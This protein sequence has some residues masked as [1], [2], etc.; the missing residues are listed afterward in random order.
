MQKLSS[1]RIIFFVIVG[2][3]LVVVCL[4][5]AANFIIKPLQATPTPAAVM[6]TG[7][8]PA[9]PA[10]ELKSPAPVF[11]PGVDTKDGLP[12][13]VCG[14]DS[15]GSYFILQQMQMS[16]KDVAHGFHLG[17][18]PF[19]LDNNPAYDVT[20]EQ[21]TALLDNG[22][23]DCLLTTLD[24][25]ALTSPGII[26]AIIDES[27]GADQLWA[28]NIKTINDLK[29]KR[30]AFSRGSVGEY[31]VYYTLSI[32]RLNPRIDVTL[33]PQDTVAEAVKAFNDGKADAVSGWEPDIYDAKKGGGVALLSSSQMR[34][35]L[36]VIVTSRQSISKKADLVQKFTD[37]WFDTLKAQEENLDS[38]A[39]QIAKWGHNDW[40]AISVA[41]ASADLK[42]ALQSLAQADLG[43]NAFVM[44]DT[45]PLVNRLNIARRVWAAS[46]AQVPADNVADLVNPGFVTRSASQASLQA[47]GKPVNDTFSLSSKLDLSGVN[48]NDAATLAVL[49]C[50]RFSFVPESTALTIESR[51][52]L[53]DCVVPTLQQSVGLFLRVKGSAAWPGPKGTYTKDDILKIAQGRA[54]SVVDY[55]VSQ[56]I[57][58][59][60]FIVESTLPP[61]SHWETDNADLQAEDRYVEMTLLTVGR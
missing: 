12:T 8:N 55:L 32:A 15:F 26:T 59:S 19:L 50:R 44:R 61:Q 21:R 13:Y 9:T 23:W 22:K 29:G 42:G 51:R 53:D 11:A 17:I 5:L 38:A 46:G 3:A 25:V 37:A 54:Q 36:D 1:T 31:F 27:A 48:T 6:V 10:V 4:A 28:R 56:G 49:P 33:V 7:Q 18:V 47:N 16:G 52:I 34:I 20:E 30:I 2:A 35:I 24:S 58:R 45:G 14:A 40:S 41:N 57:D 60:R 39:A 43:A